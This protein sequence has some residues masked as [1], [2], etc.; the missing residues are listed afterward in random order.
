MS[1]KIL[2]C[3]LLFK[4]VFSFEIP[5]ELVNSLSVRNNG[6]YTKNYTLV[7]NNLSRFLIKTAMA[8]INEMNKKGLSK[9]CIDSLES[10][11]KESNNTDVDLRRKEFFLKLFLDSSLTKNELHFY[12]NC[13]HLSHINNNKNLSIDYVYLILSVKNE[14]NKHNDIFNKTSNDYENSFYIYG[15][16]LPFKVVCSSRDYLHLFKILNDNY[17]HFFIN[18]NSTVR[19]YLLDKKDPPKL[20]ILSYIILTFLAIQAFL[21]VFNYPIFYLLNKY[22]KSKKM[23]N[24]NDNNKK[25]YNSQRWIKKLIS[26]F[27]FKDNFGELFNYSS[28]STEIN[29]YSG[30]IEIR[31]LNAISIFLTILGATFIAIYNSPLKLNGSSQI[32][33]LLGNP[34]YTLVFIGLRFSPR[35]MLSCSGYTL[36]YKFLCS[37][38]KNISIFKFIIYQSHKLFIFILLFYFYNY[39]LN[40]IIQKT[41]GLTAIPIW[42]YFQRFVLG[43]KEGDNAWSEYEYETDSKNISFTIMKNKT[44]EN[45]T[46]IGNIENIF[47][48]DIFK[49]KIDRIEQNILDY[50]W[51]LINEIIFFILGICLISIGF[52]CKI[53][54]DIFI[55]V[56]VIVILLAKF[57]PFFIKTENLFS[58]STLYYYMFD[59][60]K[61]MAKP[62]YNLPYFLIGLYFGLMNYTLQRVEINKFDRSLYSQI[63][64]FSFLKGE[65]KEEHQPILY[66]DPELNINNEE[67][68]NK[69]KIIENDDKINNNNSQIDIF[70]NENKL[71]DDNNTEITIHKSK[72]KNTEEEI[73]SF[74]KVFINIINFINRKN[75]NTYVLFYLIFFVLIIFAPIISHYLILVILYEGD[76]YENYSY[77]KRIEI[78]NNATEREIEMIDYMKQKNLDYYLGNIFL[79]I[80]YRIDIEIVIVVIHLMFFVLRANGQN[81]ILS[82]FTN[83]IWGT[84]SKFYFSFLIICNMVIL[85][86]IYSTETINTINIYNILL[87]FVYNTIIILFFTSLN[88]IFLELPFKKLIKLIFNRE[89][90]EKI[91]EEDENEEEEEDE[92]GDEEEKKKIK[93][94]KKENK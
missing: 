21:I 17:L 34:L 79:N 39:T 85:F 52:K 4:I 65:E 25:S 13:K 48:L 22:F 19:G 86:S 42:I 2:F 11:S 28:N 67:N 69:E 72:D 55:I 45:T 10:F 37:I 3:A 50:F 70:E 47:G 35:I 44:I 24:N 75:N 31:G 32:Q 5:D 60:G 93:N 49:K 27:S 33:L 87:N 40:Y 73:R 66:K 88:Y 56:F 30:L 41:F 81:N 94:N 83:I 74:L 6:N 7:E 64:D 77:N 16:C 9:N 71:N 92:D 53:K 78:N 90:E 36:V 80:L 57:V 14:I 12:D 62:L 59:Y 23:Q 61:V 1:V 43:Q 38:E 58:H 20:N 29:N 68:D 91:E 15:F 18:G 54:I 46:F 26:C 82:F 89:D 63:K 8:L 84:F 51:I 76:K